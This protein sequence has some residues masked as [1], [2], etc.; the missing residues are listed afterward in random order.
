[1]VTAE[2]VANRQLVIRDLDRT[3]TED[4]IRAASGAAIGSPNRTGEN[5][6]ISDLKKPQGGMAGMVTLHLQD[7]E[8]DWLLEAGRIRIGW[9][10]CRV[11]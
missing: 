5:I 9:N 7:V 1:M 2:V 11:Q 4:D 3:V 10:Q 8:A 6:Q